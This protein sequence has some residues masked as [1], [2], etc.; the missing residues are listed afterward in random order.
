MRRPPGMREPTLDGQSADSTSALVLRELQAMRLQMDTLTR[1]LDKLA[2][3]GGGGGGDD[4]GGGGDGGDGG[5]GV[6]VVQK[7]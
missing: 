1:R 6:P 5:N 4:G 2:P 7:I 3:A